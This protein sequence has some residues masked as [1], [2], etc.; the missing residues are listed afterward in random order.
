MLI[1]GDTAARLDKQSGRE[2][3]LSLKASDVIKELQERIELYGDL[4]VI[5]R[6]NDGDMDFDA[7]SVYGDEDTARI[8]L[9]DAIGLD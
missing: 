3:A 4:E 2:E 9:S 5:W 1:R 7:I 8:V 6:E